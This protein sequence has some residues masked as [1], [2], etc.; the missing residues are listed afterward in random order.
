MAEH[1]FQDTLPIEQAK[2]VAMAL[3]NKTFSIDLWE[4]AWVVAEYGLKQFIPNGRV[5][6]AGPI[7]E[8]D[9][10]AAGEALLAACE[11]E[12]REGL[13]QAAALPWLS[14]VKAI[15]SAILQVL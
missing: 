13:M 1:V 4:D 10:V 6:A 3:I 5:G 9:Q 12:S 11:G 14:I 8:D 2:N 7:T 15:V